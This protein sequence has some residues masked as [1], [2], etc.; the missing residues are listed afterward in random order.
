MAIDKN[1]D[2]NLLDDN[3]LI[4]DKEVGV[5]ANLPVSR[6]RAYRH[7]GGGPKFVRLGSRTVR[8]RVSA[9]REWLSTLPE[10]ANTA[11][12]PTITSELSQK[13]S[14]AANKGVAAKK[15]KAKQRAKRGAK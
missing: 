11:Q 6:F 2:L 14:D 9:V 7:K 1:T 4:T 3:T 15:K 5:F 10:Y 8:Y 13:R 12:D